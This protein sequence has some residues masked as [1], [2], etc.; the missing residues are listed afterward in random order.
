M[1]VRYRRIGSPHIFRSEREIYRGGGVNSGGI[2]QRE[3][4]FIRGDD[5]RQFGAPQDHG[6][7]APLAQ[8]IDECDGL[9]TR[10]RSEHPDAELLKD[11]TI[12]PLA[13]FCMG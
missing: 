12:E 9:G 1:Q 5:Q 11:Q 2:D 3:G 6:L 10:L 4:A 7:G 13:F 8:V